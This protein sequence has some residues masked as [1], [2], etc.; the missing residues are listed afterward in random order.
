MPCMSS[1]MY[2]LCKC[3]YR[4]FFCIFK[5]IYKKSETFS[6]DTYKR[7]AVETGNDLY[8]TAVRLRLILFSKDIGAFQT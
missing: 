7:Y 6:S 4:T 8:N 5:T 2:V 3:T 1:Y